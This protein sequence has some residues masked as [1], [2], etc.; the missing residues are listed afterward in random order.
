M[1]YLVSYTKWLLRLFSFNCVIARFGFKF[2]LWHLT[3][4][5]ILEGDLLSLWPIYFFFICK[6]EIIMRVLSQGVVFRTRLVKRKKKEKKNVTIQIINIV[7]SF[8]DLSSPISPLYAY[9]WRVKLNAPSQNS[10]PGI[11]CYP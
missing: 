8:S 11:Q 10:H 9:W 2:W 1:L 7:S 5:E 6:V 3:C 4:F